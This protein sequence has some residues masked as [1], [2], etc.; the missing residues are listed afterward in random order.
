MELEST[1]G[2]ECVGFSHEQFKWIATGGLDKLLKIWEMSSG[3]CRVTCAHD[4]GVVSLKWHPLLPFVCTGTIDA[5][6][7]VWDARNGVCT[8]LLTGH[9]N[10]VTSIDLKISSP[11]LGTIISVSDDSTARLFNVVFEI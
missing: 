4:G 2:V 3:S 11:E 5:V 6:V 7:R 9:T 8:H 1:N 10:M